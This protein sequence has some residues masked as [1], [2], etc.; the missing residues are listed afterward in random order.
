M[1]GLFY[2]RIET[3]LGTI[4]VVSDGASLCALDYADHEDRMRALLRRRFGDAQLVPRDDPNGFSGRLRAY[5]GGHTGAF[6]GVPL[7]LGGTGFQRAVWSALGRIPAGETTSYG[8]LAAA[9]GRPGAARAVGLANSRNPVAIAV[10]CH[11]VIGGDGAL[12]GY[13][14]G[15]K[16]KKWLL[17]HEARQ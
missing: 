17:E 12:T 9:I 2:D 1:T 5:F 16:R 11:R 15:L 13:A 3:E 8:A 6:D 4:L 14:G 10:P 7:N